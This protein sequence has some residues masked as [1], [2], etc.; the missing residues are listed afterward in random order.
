MKFS[1][2]LQKN[3]E[4]LKSVLSSDD[5]IFMPVSFGEKNA[6]IIFITDIVDKQQISEFIIKPL[7]V[8][9]SD[10]NT[11]KE[12]KNAFLS[13]DVKEVFSLGDCIT[14]IVKG[15]TILLFEGELLAFSFALKKI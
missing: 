14:E 4:Y 7:K 3:V 8:F 9:Y 13:P 15:N 11:E 5:V 10:L 12:L 6:S 1:N 2:N